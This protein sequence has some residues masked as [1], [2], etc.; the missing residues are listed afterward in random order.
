MLNPS[1][2]LLLCLLFTSLIL[3]FP[4]AQAQTTRIYEVVHPTRAVAGNPDPIPVT[5]TVLYNDTVPGDHLTVSILDLDMGPSQVAAGVATSSP[6]TCTN[7][8]VLLAQC[9]IKTTGASGAEHLEFKIGGSMAKTQRAPG[10]WDLSLTI[11]L[12]DANG[13]V[14]QGSA[15]SVSFQIVLTPTPLLF[16]K[17]PGSVT[18]SLDGTNQTMGIID[19]AEISVG[20]HTLSVP[21]FATATNTARLRFDHWSDGVT[22]ASRSILARSDVWLE[23]VYA[24]QHR[25]TL[26]STLGVTSGEGWYD[27][28]STATIAAPGSVP[29]SGFAGII[30]AK[31]TFSGWYENGRLVAASPVAK[32]SVSQ[33]HTLTATWQ[34]DYSIP[35]LVVAA[36][37]AILALAYVATRKKTRPA[38][39]RRARSRR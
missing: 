22:D 29:M 16:V 6:D 13:N 2:T 18:I 8:P 3:T 9:V 38:R 27:A 1:K 32:I 25:L 26:N 30:G 39:S 15:S 31:W 12:R 19:G 35:L 10:P 23:A 17:V 33:A 36:I 28:N 20:E 24:T 7:N 11:D 4:S 37:V 14:I 21:Q 34:A 5:A